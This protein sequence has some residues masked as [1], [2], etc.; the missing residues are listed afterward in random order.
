MHNSVDNLD[1]QTFHLEA[2]V[3]AQN[4][5]TVMAG[6]QPRALKIVP[7]GTYGGQTSTP[8]SRA[9]QKPAE[10]GPLIR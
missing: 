3:P 2:A 1:G 9:Q 5:R 7:A 4:G 6:L 10:I 8:A